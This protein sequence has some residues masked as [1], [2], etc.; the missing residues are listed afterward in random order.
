MVRVRR[1]GLMRL[2]VVGLVVWAALDLAMTGFCTVDAATMRTSGVRMLTP[3]PT[4]TTAT[5]SSSCDC[6][7]CF[8]AVRTPTAADVTPIP[9]ITWRLCVVLEQFA[10]IHGHTLYHPP[11]LPSSSI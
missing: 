5:T 10:G 8:S 9:T 4:R 2:F 3:A 6:F 7:C 11:Q 1:T